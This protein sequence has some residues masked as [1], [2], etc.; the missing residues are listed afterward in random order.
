MFDP[1][2]VTAR[3]PKKRFDGFVEII[4]GPSALAKTSRRYCRFESSLSRL[5]RTTLEHRIQRSDHYLKHH[6][7]Y[8]QSW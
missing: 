3:L 5:V 2:V 7:I 8:L 4:F 6:N 1:A